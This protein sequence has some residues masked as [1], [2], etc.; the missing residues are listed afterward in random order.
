MNDNELEKILDEIKNNKESN[1]SLDSNEFE[2]ILNSLN[3]KGAEEE[4]VV[5]DESAVDDEI[6]DDAPLQAEPT[7]EPDSFMLEE[8]AEADD[9]FMPVHDIVAV[10]YTHL[11]LPTKA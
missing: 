6:I 10:S 3:S 1:N 7:Q 2:E 11:T 4:T 5:A 8:K 9:E